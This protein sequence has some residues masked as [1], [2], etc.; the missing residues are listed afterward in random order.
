MHFL[1]E[2]RP[3]FYPNIWRTPMPFTAKIAKALENWRLDHRSR[4]AR[5]DLK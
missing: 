2:V 1:S 3:E 4:L 5:A